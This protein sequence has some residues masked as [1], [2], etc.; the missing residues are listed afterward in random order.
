MGF[1]LAGEAILLDSEYEFISSAVTFG[2]IQLLPDGQ[3]IVLMADQQT[4]GGYPRVAHVITRDLPLM[5]QL[6]PNDKVA[7][8]PVTI[9]EAEALA[10][11]FEGELNLFKV[12]CRLLW[13]A[14]S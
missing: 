10:A 7:F 3:L 6:G 2:T 14:A 12:G 9:D 13:N 5:A 11:E 4:S 8:H 1:R